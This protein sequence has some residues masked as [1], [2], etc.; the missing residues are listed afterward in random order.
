L[1]TLIE[2]ASG[3]CSVF[4]DRNEM[5]AS[6][7]WDK[8]I[9]LWNKNTGD[10]LRTLIGHVSGVSSFSFDNISSVIAFVKL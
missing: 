4:F 2:H 1:R 7:S 6:G 5:L 8:T 3:V 9:K 10:L